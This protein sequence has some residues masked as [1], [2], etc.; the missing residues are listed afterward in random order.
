RKAD[1]IHRE[2]GSQSRAIEAVLSIDT[3]HRLLCL[4]R[5]LQSGHSGRPASKQKRT[6]RTKRQ[7]VAG[8]D[9]DNELESRFGDDTR[10][11]SENAEGVFSQQPRVASGA[12]LPWVTVS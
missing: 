5:R 3:S 8:V 11:D 7:E 12:K 1:A 9:Q 10:D 2:R 6:I 4:K